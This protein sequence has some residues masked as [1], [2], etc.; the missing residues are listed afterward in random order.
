MPPSG[1]RGAYFSI[2]DL[3][4]LIIDA[5]I[6]LWWSGKQSLRE[7]LKVLGIVYLG[8][9]NIVLY[10]ELTLDYLGSDKIRRLVQGAGNHPTRMLVT[11]TVVVIFLLIQHRHEAL[12]TRSESE[13][14]RRVCELLQLSRSAE[15]QRSIAEVLALYFAVFD[16]C[17][18]AHVSIHLPDGNGKL[19]MADDH[20][21]PPGTA[22]SF[23]LELPPGK[24][25]AQKVFADN[26]SNS[27]YVPFTSIF[28]YDFPHC[29]RFAW[30]QDPPKRF[31][32]RRLVAWPLYKFKGMSTRLADRIA[33]PLP[34]FLRLVQ[35]GVDWFGFEVPK[36]RIR[37]FQ[38]MLSVP[39]WHRKQRRCLGV[40]NFDFS[41]T[42]T[43]E[44]SDVMIGMLLG[45]LLA[46][47]HEEIFGGKDEHSTPN[48][49]HTNTGESGRVHQ[50]TS[51]SSDLRSR[52]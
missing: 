46:E 48:G 27:R 49:D 4:R 10:L 43:L 47:E 15:A 44:R 34:R 25:A 2:K 24:G 51:A 45:V 38:S 12:Q 8:F 52:T 18:I 41:Q 5:S 33:K 26:E 29:V 28:N 30:T 22:S 14:V 13:Y 3:P 32:L 19:Q 42:E 31:W 1:N 17:H 40:L 9:S 11:S 20:V 35:T 21:Y 50:W 6:L 7:R 16:G 36:D 23:C 37:H 39:I